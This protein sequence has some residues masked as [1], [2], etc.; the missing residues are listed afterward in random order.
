MK[1]VQK[2]ERHLHEEMWENNSERME[3]NEINNTKLYI[4]ERI[5]T[6]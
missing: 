1:E 5:Q 4:K 3:E 6:Y 2:N